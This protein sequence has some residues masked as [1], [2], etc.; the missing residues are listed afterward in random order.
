LWPLFVIWGYRI[1]LAFQNWDIVWHKIYI[2]SGLFLSAHLQ[3]Q[4]LVRFMCVLEWRLH[5]LSYFMHAHIDYC[6]F[7]G[8]IIN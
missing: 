6:I 1:D 5:K 7:G 2:L 4:M 3:L 8:K